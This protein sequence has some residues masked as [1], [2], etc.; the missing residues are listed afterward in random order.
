MILK[1]CFD[2]D[3]LLVLRVKGIVLPTFLSRLN[4]ISGG[5]ENILPV[6]RSFW[7][8]LKLSSKAMILAVMNAISFCNCV[9]KPQKF[10]TSTGFELVTSRNRYDALTN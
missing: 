8:N 3:I 7:S 5:C 6:S 10:R 2:P 9:K 1:D 4:E